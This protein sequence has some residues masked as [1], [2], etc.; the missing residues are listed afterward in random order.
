M[1]TN[2]ES[3]KEKLNALAHSPN[4]AFEDLT[5]ISNVID[6]EVQEM[7]IINADKI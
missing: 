5:S 7:L 6:N 3:L 4:S 1:S 2:L